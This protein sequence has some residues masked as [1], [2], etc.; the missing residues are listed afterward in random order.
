MRFGT[1]AQWSDVDAIW[2]MST[3]EW[4]WW[5][6]ALGHIRRGGG[7]L[8]CRLGKLA[9]LVNTVWLGTRPELTAHAVIWDMSTVDECNECIWD[10]SRDDGV[11][12]C[13]VRYIAY[14]GNRMLFGT[15]PQG[16]D[17][18]VI[19]DTSSGLKM[20]GWKVMCLLSTKWTKCELGHTLSGIITLTG[21]GFCFLS[22]KNT[23]DGAIWDT[24][25][26]TWDVCD[27]VYLSDNTFT[28][29]C[30][31]LFLNVGTS[32]QGDILNKTP[33]RAAMCP[34]SCP[35]IGPESSSGGDG[36]I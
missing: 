16:T 34:P 29:V 3:V 4:C 15:H 32:E 23:D 10:I 22:S 2:D 9:Y 36:E 28:L 7:T 33:A 25:T 11:L 6:C 30:Y 26:V 12:E 8:D 14:V 35:L 13:N 18:G 21:W 31:F 19:W 17:F 24:S 5:W 20:T 27:V 1:H